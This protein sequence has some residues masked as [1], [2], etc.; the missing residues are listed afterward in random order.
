MS[1]GDLLDWIRC[2]RSAAE[3]GVRQYVQGRVEGLWQLYRYRNG[4]RLWAANQVE[5]LRPGLCPE[6]A[7]EARFN[8]RYGAALHRAQ[9]FAPHEGFQRS[10]FA[11]L[12]TAVD[13]APCFTY[14]NGYRVGEYATYLQRMLDWAE[15]HDVAVVLVDMPV[16]ADLEERLYP[17][18]F[19][20]F[21]TVLGDVQ[22]QRGVR[23][24]RA[25]RS[26]VGLSDADFA[27]LIHLNA[28]GTA[29]LSAWL[30]HALEE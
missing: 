5:Q 19:A 22:Q 24:L 29:R 25:S 9:G 3:W 27:D 10:C 26:A 1:G 15:A 13:L 21:R 6:A 16:S 30:R 4:I 14:L 2:R 7:T 8:Q 28:H 20:G 23:V 17:Q 11:S 18:V 12:K